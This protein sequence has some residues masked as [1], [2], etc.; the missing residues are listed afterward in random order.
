SHACGEARSF[1]MCAC[2]AHITAA[3]RGSFCTRTASR[4]VRIGLRISSRRSRGQV[5]SS[6]PVA[7]PRGSVPIADLRIVRARLTLAGLTKRF[8]AHQ[9][10]RPLGAAVVHELHGLLPSFVLEEHDREIALLLEIE[11]DSSADPFVRTVD[12]LPRHAPILLQLENSHVEDAEL[13]S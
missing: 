1:C 2:M 11:A 13:A 5:H 8:Q 6:V 7:E 4:P 12:D 10:D 9:E 3:M